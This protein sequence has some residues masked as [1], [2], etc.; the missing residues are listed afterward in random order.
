MIKQLL[1]IIAAACT[2][3]A[4]KAQPGSIK[5]ERPSQSDV[6]TVNYNTADARAVLNGKDSIYARVTSFIQD[7]S[8]KKFHVKLPGNGSSIS[9]TFS[10]PP[11]SVSFNVEFYT[12]NKD[13]NASAANL[14]V[15]QPDHQKPVQGA[16]MQA[17]F[18]DRPDSIFSKETV[19]Y[20]ENYLAYAKYINVVSMIK[21]ADI[22]K[23]EIANLLVKLQNVKAKSAGWLAAMCIGYAKTGYLAEGKTYLYQLFSKYPSAAETAFAFSIY[24]YEYY[25]ASTKDVEE[26]VRTAL[27]DIFVKHPDAEIC[28]DE[29]V[30]HYLQNE[31]DISTA[32]F[33]RVLK[34]MYADGSIS[35]HA[36]YNL[37]EIY[38]ARNEKLDTA[39]MILVN[40]IRQYQDGT[41][42]HQYRLNNGHYQ[43]YVPLLLM[44]LVKVNLLQKNHERAINNASA[45]LNI[46]T[47]SNTEGNFMPLLLS[48]RADAYSQ[49]GNYNLALADYKKLYR[50]GNA[51][52][53]DSMRVIFTQCDVKQKTFDEF[54][55]S[56]KPSAGS[57]KGAASVQLAPLFTATDMQGNIIKLSDLKGKLVILNIW[58]IGCG[59]CVAEMPRLNELVKQYGTRNDVVFLAITGDKNEDLK[60]FFKTRHFDYRVVNKVANLSETFNT[61]A[62]PVHMV[63]GKQGQIISRSIGARSDIKEYLQGLIQANL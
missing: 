33:E 39:A 36:L 15:Y 32:S 54:A 35:Y 11:G 23:P 24:N 21:N 8:V 20:P 10:L 43:M 45:A 59:P 12:L 37:P 22:A 55:A 30:F 2:I 19:N 26:D 5:P 56:L 31:K 48:L 42:N 6:I 51:A 62:L 13:D 60:V 4:V 61:N 41:I 28:R 34:P 1:F 46:L 49:S 16:Y 50:D 52:V 18:S 25:K 47:G 29:N 44:D 38:I 27:K 7:G 58:G 14:L 9:N 3:S 40:G 57:D 17:M 53:L 63:V